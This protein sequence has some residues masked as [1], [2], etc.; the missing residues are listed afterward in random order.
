MI[1]IPEQIFGVTFVFF[2]STT[3]QHCSSIRKAK[4]LGI[5]FSLG[6]LA[7][8]VV[9]SSFRDGVRLKWQK[10]YLPN[11]AV[12]PNWLD[13]FSLDSTLTLIYLRSNKNRIAGVAT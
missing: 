12:S 10:S 1:V 8:H 2:S 9:L 7:Q 5:L 13:Q 3:S 4:D 11:K 6:L